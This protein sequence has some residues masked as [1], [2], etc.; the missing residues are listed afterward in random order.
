MAIASLEFCFSLQASMCTKHM[1]DP[2]SPLP[3]SNY[4]EPEN[5]SP[6]TKNFQSLNKMTEQ[7]LV[8][9]N[10][11]QLFQSIVVSL[12]WVS[13][14]GHWNGPA[15]ETTI[16]EWSLEC[17]SS[18]ITGLPASSFFMGCLIGGLI[19]GT[20]A[21]SSLG[22]KNLLLISCLIMSV[23]ALITSFANNIWTY[24]ALR[25]I[26]GFGCASIGT[27]A[28]VLLTEKVGEQWRGRVGIL[29]FFFFTCGFLSLPLIAYI[30]RFSIWRVLYLWTSIPGIFYCSL[31]HF[32][33]HRVP[34]MA[35]HA[36]LRGRSNV[37]V[38]DELDRVL[39][40]L[41]HEQENKNHPKTTTIFSSMKTLF[42]KTWAF[43]RILA[44]ITLG[45]GIGL[46]YY[47]M[48]FG[49]GNLGFN[50]YLSVMFNALSEIPSYFV[51]YMP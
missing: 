19:L 50:I 6:N 13:L 29:G 38:E 11:A 17:A 35:L 39:A 21:D 28:L 36:Q 32:F 42:E 41:A 46:V 2:T 26:S 7:S 43:K 15:S 18:F 9:F 14:L 24:S 1:D 31:L 8:A 10:W 12:A 47:G 37:T 49:V 51:T 22:R 44:V 20:L 48:P 3:P 16:S 4:S 27:C 5:L 33:C 34:K 45:T 23:A 40:K 30:N 25:F